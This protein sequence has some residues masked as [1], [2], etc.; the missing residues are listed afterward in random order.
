MTTP[1][2]PNLFQ[3]S[4]WSAKRQWRQCDQILE[5]PLQVATG[6]GDPMPIFGHVSVATIR[7]WA[8]WLAAA[9]FERIDFERGARLRHARAPEERLSTGLR[10]C[11][12]AGLDALPKI[13]G[14]RFP[15]R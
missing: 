5:N 11:L 3:R 13:L 2:E 10:V 15:T 12:E 8:K 7:E 9:G 4:S 6:N 14:A 1:N